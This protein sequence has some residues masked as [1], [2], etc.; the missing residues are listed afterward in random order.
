[1]F[2]LPYVTLCYL[3]ALDNAFT[4][5]CIKMGLDAAEYQHG[6][7]ICILT[8]QGTYIKAYMRALPCRSPRG[9]R[10]THQGCSTTHKF[11]S[12]N[13]THSKYMIQYNLVYCTCNA[14]NLA[15]LNDW[16]IYNYNS[17]QII[18]T[19]SIKNPPNNHDNALV[20]IINKQF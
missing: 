6:L 19:L 12:Y 3:M 4:I 14:N 20:T 17:Y 13:C 16:D 8:G 9:K 1:M 18:N 10:R 11:H 5:K 15:R 7:N 2:I